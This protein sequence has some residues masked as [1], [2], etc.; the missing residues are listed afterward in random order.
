[1]HI[2]RAQWSLLCMAA[3]GVLQCYRSIRLVVVAVVR[4]R[5]R[6]RPR[7]SW[8]QLQDRTPSV[9]RVGY[10]SSSALSVWWPASDRSR[11]D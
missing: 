11:D 3:D 1:M 6:R 2:I 4:L 9:W 5:P 7:P 8:Q 10:G